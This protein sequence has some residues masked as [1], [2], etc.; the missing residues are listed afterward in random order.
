MLDISFGTYLIFISFLTFQT[1]SQSICRNLNSFT[2]FHLSSV[3]IV[4]I[5]EENAE[6]NYYFEDG[7][8]GY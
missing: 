2:D 7:L 8:R 1:C 5:G 3:N 6:N 4:K